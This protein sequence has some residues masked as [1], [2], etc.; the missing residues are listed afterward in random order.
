MH[1]FTSHL[2]NHFWCMSNFTSAVKFGGFVKY[3][4]YNLIQMIRPHTSFQVEIISLNMLCS[5]CMW[6]KV[7]PLTCM[8]V[9]HTRWVLYEVL[10][11]SRNWTLEEAGF[12]GRAACGYA[13]HEKPGIPAVE[14]IWCCIDKHGQ[15]LDMYLQDNVNYAGKKLRNPRAEWGVKSWKV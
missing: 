4:Q 9:I 10:V 2:K 14:R 12:C 5:L 3:F 7:L 11:H 15:V 8:C 6:I 13:P 1:E